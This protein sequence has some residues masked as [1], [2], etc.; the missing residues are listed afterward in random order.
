MLLPA[1]SKA[2]GMARGTQCISNLKQNSYVFMQY[3][4]DNEDYY[5]PAQGPT[6]WG[7]TTWNE[8][9]TKISSPGADSYEQVQ[10]LFCP[11]TRPISPYLNGVY[12]G[13]HPGYGVMTGG[14]TN[15]RYTGRQMIAGK[16][17]SYTPF[18]TTQIRRPN[19]SVLLSD[20]KR[21]YPEYNLCGYAWI[22]NLSRTRSDGIVA[23]RH[24]KRDNYAFCDGHV[25]TIAATI[26]NQWIDN[27]STTSIEYLYGELTH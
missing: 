6:A 18:K 16:H 1:L 5:I 19:I 26:V 10:T 8:T 11:E 2:K 23:E 3:A 25:S 9:F 13:S 17:N 24:N 12:N 7:T 14:P 20:S 22:W 4:D 21:N 15:N 27:S